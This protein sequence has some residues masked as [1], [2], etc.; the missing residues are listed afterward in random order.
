MTSIVVYCTNSKLVI[1]IIIDSNCISIRIS[2]WEHMQIGHSHTTPNT[3]R[4]KRGKN[5]DFMPSTCNVHCTYIENYIEV[6]ILVG[7]AAFGHWPNQMFYSLIE[8]YLHVS[9]ALNKK[10]IMFC[11]FIIMSITSCPQEK[12]KKQLIIRQTKR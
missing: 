11:P 8:I 2:E 10:C 12:K 3:V 4:N 1:I 9:R 6:A 7:R 5:R